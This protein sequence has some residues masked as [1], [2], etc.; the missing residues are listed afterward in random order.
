MKLTQINIITT[1][2][3]TSKDF[4]KVNKLIDVT[5]MHINGNIVIKKISKE[6]TFKEMEKLKND[7]SIA[8]LIP[9]NKILFTYDTDDLF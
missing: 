8:L 7:I 9:A 2:P 6:V 4:D 3:L 1:R 5:D